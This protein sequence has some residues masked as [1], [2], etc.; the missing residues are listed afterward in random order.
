MYFSC[1]LVDRMMSEAESGLFMLWFWLIL[2]SFISHAKLGFI[3]PW[4][5]VKIDF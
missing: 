1:I 3:K 4:F 5:D 2:L